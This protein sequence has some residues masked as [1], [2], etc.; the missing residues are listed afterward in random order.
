MKHKFFGTRIGQHQDIFTALGAALTIGVLASLA[1]MALTLLLAR[2]A[3]AADDITLNDVDHGSLLFRTQSP[4]RFIP[5]PALDTTVSIKVTGFVAR[6]SVRQRFVNT[7][8]DWMEGVYVFPLPENSAVDHLRMHIGTRVLEGQ[9]KERSEAKRVYEQAKQDGKK[10]S[11]VEQERPNLFTTSVANI[12]PND[13][14]TIEIE[15][16]QTV[17]YDQGNFRLRFPMTLTPRYIP[18]MPEA[19]TLHHE[20]TEAPSA[21]AARTTTPVPGSLN[22][23][24]VPDADRISPP[25]LPG[26]LAAQTTTMHVVLEPG[27]PLLRT[28][29]PSHA[30]TSESL[31]A[32]RTAIA[33]AKG[34]VPTDRD[35]ELV[36]T[37]VL[38]AEPQAAVFT[39]Q[40]DGA[41][42]HLLMV[43]P[44]DDRLLRTQS[45]PREV[46]FIIDTS[47]S[48]SGTSMEQA[49]RALLMAL[50]RLQ[51]TDRFNV[52]EFNSV[53]HALFDTAYFADHNHVA[54]AKQFVNALHA[55]GGTEIA[56]ALRAALD[57]IREHAMLRQVIFLTDGS[58]GNEDA[59]FDLIQSRL[60]DSRLFTVGIG[61]APNSYFM[62]K[63]AA[64]GCGTFTYISDVSE[65]QERMLALFEK[66]ERPA[67][68]DLNVTWPATATVEAW[69]QRLPDLYA[70]E[71]L[72]LSVR[73]NM[74]RGA[75]VVT[76][77]RN[78]TAWRKVLPLGESTP[79]T[80]LHVLWARA[81]IDALMDAQNNGL[82]T[83]QVREQVIGV[84]LQHHLVSKFTSLVAVDITPSRMREE[85]LHSGAVPNA[86]PAGQ[87]Y[88]KIL[89][90]LPQTAT[91]AEL[92]ID[93]GLLLLGLALLGGIALR[94]AS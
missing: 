90:Q 50:E 19:L 37:P 83:E 32:R 46:I 24:E 31:D 77:N 40:Q 18:G 43:L 67:M 84:A 3:S 71:P 69:P 38:G 57:G 70:G 9:I 11:L 42:Y 13:E 65:V 44:P 48:M 15:Y 1:L 5:A 58:V 16:Q 52:I 10:A 30:I 81:K 23:D 62:K 87:S 66:L 36:W 6:A 21:T 4:G 78:F 61:S 2:A 75:L 86:L 8:S 89:G 93:A 20:D 88:A 92:L 85:L 73:T 25:M 64:A 54:R 41:F 27:F 17:R 39:E 82:S 49:K 55:N 29:S 94:R 22:T 76:G 72:M 68:K 14:I 59:L 47:G 74:H 35:F 28:H 63:A 60:G 34:A 33:F 51:P 45:V 91:P 7:S 26:H 53:T 12:A 80:G 79:A 56:G